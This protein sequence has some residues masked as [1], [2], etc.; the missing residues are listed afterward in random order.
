MSERTTLTE[1]EVT[2][3]KGKLEMIQHLYESGADHAAILKSLNELETLLAGET[4]AK[5]GSF[6]LNSAYILCDKLLFPRLSILH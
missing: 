1:I 4:V 2:A 3:C 6:L 5:E